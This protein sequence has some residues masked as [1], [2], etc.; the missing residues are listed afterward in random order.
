MRRK[1]TLLRPVILFRLH[2]FILIIEYGS[3]LTSPEDKISL[4]KEKLIT[5]KR[6][7]TAKYWGF[8]LVHNIIK[9]SRAVFERMDDLIVFAVKDENQIIKEAVRILNDINNRSNH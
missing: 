6:L 7:E 5:M 3:V 9:L 4:E 1:D 8:A 2:N